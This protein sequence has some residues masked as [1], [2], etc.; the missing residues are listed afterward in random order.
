MKY[1]FFW[2]DS[3]WFVCLF[4]SNTFIRILLG[5]VALGW[6]SQVTGCSF[7]VYF[8]VIFFSKRLIFVLFPRSFFFLFLGIPVT[9]YL[10]FITLIFVIILQ[11]LFISS[12]IPLDLFPVRHYLLYLVLCVYVCYVFFLLIYSSVLKY[13]FWVLFASFWIFLIFYCFFISCS[14]HYATL[15]HF[16]M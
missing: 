15:F 6:Y 10:L 9:V 5:L 7:N 4:K 12:F 2:L 13:F 11:I 3:Q 14:F 16:E 8:T 1:M